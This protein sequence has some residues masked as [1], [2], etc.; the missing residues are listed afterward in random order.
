MKAKQI[1][2]IWQRNE[3]PTVYEN[4]QNYDKSPIEVWHA[5]GWRE[6]TQPIVD[7][8]LQ[9]QTSE[10]IVVESQPYN[11]CTFKVENYTAE[12][13]VQNEA[14]RLDALDEAYI[15]QLEE[16]GLAIVRRHRKRLR[17]RVEENTTSF[18][19]AK[20][21]RKLLRS[22]WQELKDCDFDWALTDAQAIDQT[23]LNNGVKREV[24]WLITRVQ[25]LVISNPL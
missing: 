11:H 16:S 23:S 4:T 18:E 10:I 20:Q 14:N 6:L 15:N 3:L 9:Y 24:N 21:V 7:P 19:D 5:D 2:G 13:L 25:E 22:I 12:Q 1:N 17:R 8:I